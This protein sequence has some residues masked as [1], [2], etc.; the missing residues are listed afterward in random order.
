MS[1]TE[2]DRPVQDYAEAEITYLAPG[3]FINRR[4]VGPGFEFSTGIYKPYKV[5]IG[6]AR[7]AP[8]PFTLDNNGFQ[9]F[10]HKSAVSDFMDKEQVD[11]LYPNEVRDA[12][13]QFTGADKV[14]LQ[15]WMVRTSGDLTKYEHQT[16]G[17]SHQGGVQ[18]PAAEAHVDYLPDRANDL[19]AMTYKR[20]FPDGK[21]F[22]RFIATSFWRTFSE[23]PQDWPLALCD[24]RSVG[25]D[26]GVGNVLVVVDKRP[27]DEELRTPLPPE[28]E[29]TAAAVFR[30]S[31]N[32][33]WW[34]YP[35][36]TRDEVLFF[37]FHDSDQSK[38]WRTPHTAFHDHTYPNAK[39]RKSIEVRSVA[40][41]E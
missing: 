27:T 41:F 3:D 2:L 32:H 14:A 34:Y 10:K 7:T 12:I 38:A 5:R 39:E 1:T 16:E 23:P 4:Y 15:G 21:G 31:P 28:M 8:E 9:L 33:R 11:R 22:K 36:M 25:A 35:N 37:K 24:G 13:L 29:K 6:N 26:E 18:P 17:Y 20:A 19:A 30:Y 40:F